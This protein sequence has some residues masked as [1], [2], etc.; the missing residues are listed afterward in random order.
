MACQPGRVCVAPAAVGK[1]ARL[2]FSRGGPRQELLA[3][4]RFPVRAAEPGLPSA[5]HDARGAGT[6]VPGA[7]VSSSATSSRR[8][9]GGAYLGQ[10]N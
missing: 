1:R 6:D 5:L 10:L 2:S 7:P 9:G 4:L 3:R 8:K